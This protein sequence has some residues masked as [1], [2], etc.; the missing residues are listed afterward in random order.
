[1]LF[2]IVDYKDY[3]KLYVYDPIGKSKNI[4]NEQKHPR[5]FM[6]AFNFCNAI[7]R[8]ITKNDRFD[9]FKLGDYGLHIMRVHAPKLMRSNVCTSNVKEDIN[10]ASVYFMYYRCMLMSGKEKKIVKSRHGQS[11]L[12]YLSDLYTEVHDKPLTKQELSVPN[13][14]HQ[15]LKYFHATKRFSYHLAL[16]IAYCM[17]I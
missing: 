7:V 5:S 8:N 17:S 9:Y 11:C 13:I 15:Q 3:F 14:Y 10:E 6:Y 16:Y 2:E 12:M 4:K 1:M